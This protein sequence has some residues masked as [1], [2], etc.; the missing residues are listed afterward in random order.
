MK[1]LAEVTVGSFNAGE[2]AR[3]A[4]EEIKALRKGTMAA[5]FAITD[6]EVFVHLSD[7]YTDI[8]FILLD[9]DGTIIGWRNT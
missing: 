1:I 3:K 7:K 9:N 6:R 5:N 8:T 4:V 2:A